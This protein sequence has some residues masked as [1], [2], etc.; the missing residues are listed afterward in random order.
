[1]ETWLAQKR[2]PWVRLVTPLVLNSGGEADLLTG[3]AREM[4]LPGLRRY[5]VWRTGRYYAAQTET[6]E[7]L[8]FRPPAEV[9][10]LQGG[11]ESQAVLAVPERSRFGLA[12][13]ESAA[14]VARWFVD[15]VGNP[16]WTYLGW[17]QV[18]IE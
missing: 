12:A 15:G 7:P 9:D 17:G 5:R 18:V 8:G 1:L 14:D 13:G 11:A 2:A 3:A 16:S 4:M 10:Y 6:F